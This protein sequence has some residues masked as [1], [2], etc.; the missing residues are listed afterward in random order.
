MPTRFFPSSHHALLV[1]LALFLLRGMDEL[2]PVATPPATTT[3]ASDRD[4]PVCQAATPFEALLPALPVLLPVLGFAF[5]ARTH[6]VRVVAVEV[7]SLPR[8]ALSYFRNLVP[9]A[10]AI[11][12]P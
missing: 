1:L 8:C 11:K 12:G 3:D 6:Q 4:A 10:I 9:H 2:R 5:V 7:R